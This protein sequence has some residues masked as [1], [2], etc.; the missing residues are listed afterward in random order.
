[1]GYKA[2][3][4]VFDPPTEDFLSHPLSI[5]YCFDKH[6]F[7]G[8]GFLPP[9]NEGTLTINLR[10]PPGASLSE[11]NKIGT[12]AETS[13]KEIPEVI[14]VARRTGRAEQDEHAEGV[15]NS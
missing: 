1:M 12:L 2:I 11:S 4:L 10:L 14:S 7:L 15:N 3:E 8:K 9:F 6:S 13:L 5:Y